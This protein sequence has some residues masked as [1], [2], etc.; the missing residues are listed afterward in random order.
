MFR[1]V[2]FAWDAA[3]ADQT[4]AARA[5]TRSVQRSASD[6]RVVFACDGMNVLCAGERPS[7]MQAHLLNARAG[8]VLGT[9]FARPYGGG[10]ATLVQAFRPDQSHAIAA[11]R[12]RALVEAYWGRYVAFLRDPHD[13]TLR[14]IRDPVGDIECLE[15]TVNGVR[16]FFSSLASSRLAERIHLTPN[17]DYIAASLCFP[18]LDQRE[19]GLREVARVLA[20][21]CVEIRGREQ[22]RR[23]YWHPAEVARRDEVDD[24]ADAVERL[25]YT[26]RACTHA[27]AACYRS[28]I[29]KLSGGLDSSILLALL[30]EAPS[31]PDILCLNLFCPDDPDSDEREY[32]RVAAQRASK[33]LVTYEPEAGLDIRRLLKAAPFH[34]PSNLLPVLGCNEPAWQIARARGIPATFTGVGG[35]QIFFVGGSAYACADRIFRQGLDPRAIALAIAAARTRKLSV[36]SVLTEA[37]SLAWTRN[38]RKRLISIYQPPGFVSP[39]VAA[40]VLEKRLFL[41]PWLSDTDDLPPGKVMHILNLADTLGVAVTGPFAAADDPDY[42]HPLFAQPLKELCLQIPIPVLASGGRSRALVRTAFASELP[43]EIYRRRTKGG[44]REYIRRLVADNVDLMRE[45]VLDGHLVRERIVDRAPVERLLASLTKEPR[46][47]SSACLLFSTEAWLAGWLSSGR[48][49]VAA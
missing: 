13:G 40:A 28:L 33:P 36:W 25:R 48:D 38:R 34:S 12:G 41:H 2:A 44:P 32:A 47:A 6:W 16:I 42:V 11:S 24:S 21:Q 5:L 30:A 9:V 29:L 20:G 45:V 7:S 19:T 3:H 1:Y 39:D 27:W 43:Q 35:D 49:A 10:P 37:L 22:S 46:A 18:M 26:A 4:E 23:F 15:A 14:V 31:R 17:W 8:V